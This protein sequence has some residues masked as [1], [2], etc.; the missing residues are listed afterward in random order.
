MK[1]ILVT[2]LLLGVVLLIYTAT[3]GGK[4]GMEDKVRSGGGRIHTT[5]ERLNP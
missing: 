2:I 1:D 3:V 5:I 4:D